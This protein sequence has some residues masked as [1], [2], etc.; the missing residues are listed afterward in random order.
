MTN[1][2]ELVGKSFRNRKTNRV[3][4]IEDVNDT[5]VTISNP[6]GEITSISLN[7]LIKNC[8]ALEGTL[9]VESLI[10]G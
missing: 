5:V 6:D 7:F 2:K 3:Y 4:V 8:E 10:C 9:Q 1:A